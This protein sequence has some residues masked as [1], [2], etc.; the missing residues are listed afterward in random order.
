MP[1]NRRHLARAQAILAET[2]SKRERRRL[3]PTLPIVDTK[4]VDKDDR[5]HV[6][7]ALRAH[8]FQVCPWAK[9]KYPD[10]GKPLTFVETRVSNDR[11]WS[12]PTWGSNLGIGSLTFR[13]PKP[14]GPTPKVPPYA[15]EVVKVRGK[16]VTSPNIL[17]AR[18]RIGARD[19]GMATRVGWNAVKANAANAARI[20]DLNR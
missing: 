7:S 2:P 17:A 13:S 3:V 5:P 1:T 15:G 10:A 19:D 16:P 18:K 20:A 14:P 8:N 11:K 12:D 9:A 6:P 4:Y